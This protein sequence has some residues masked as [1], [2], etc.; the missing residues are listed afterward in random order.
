MS[1]D[2]PAHGERVSTRYFVQSLEKGLAVIR[3][4]GADRP[5]MSVTEVAERTGL[6]RA[7]AR[8]FLLTL[9][10]MGY[11]QAKNR[12]FSLTPRVLELGYAYLS[13]L[14]VPEVALPHL[15]R[16]VSQV[17]ES[18]EVS[19][20]D[21]EDIVYVLR[22]PGPQIVTVAIN[23]GARMPAHATSMGRVLLAGLPDDE[24]ERYLAT[25]TL[26]E[27]LPST[28]TDRKQLSAELERVRR[29]G[30]ALVDQELEPGLR[31]IAVPI[32]DRN[33]QP[34]AAA[35]LSTHV[36]RRTVAALRQELLPA[37][38]EAA[39]KIEEDLRLAGAA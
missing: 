24:L 36:A 17:E 4:F 23:V 5:T 33:G 37:L 39:A 22:V 26:Q 27:F 11:V 21:G 31:A 16:L 12:A 25:A 32:R 2:R 14:S 13:G 7:A 38:S 20:L 18:S 34:I 30:W 6:T 1:V 28:I 8:R 29:R 15:E 35:N 3:A 9:A 19:I 10:D